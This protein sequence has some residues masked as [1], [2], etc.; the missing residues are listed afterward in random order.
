M[1]QA[2]TRWGRLTCTLCWY[3]ICKELWDDA[4]T[5]CPDTPSI[6]CEMKL[7][8]DLRVEKTVVLS[9]KSSIALEIHKKSSAKHPEQSVLYWCSTK[10]IKRIKK[11]HC[12]PNITQNATPSTSQRTESDLPATAGIT[13]IRKH[14]TAEGEVVDLR[15]EQLRQESLFSPWRY[16]QNGLLLFRY[17]P[18]NL[19]KL[20][21][22]QKL[23]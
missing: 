14:H 21:Y 10:K 20:I 22:K 19:C 18:L 5:A 23:S 4:G 6:R 2:P 8:K 1:L 9:S 3:W 16:N 11:I 15:N 13:S 7:L 17:T 12:C